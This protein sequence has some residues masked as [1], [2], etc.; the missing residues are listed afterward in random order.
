M[1]RSSS[2]SAV[3]ALALGLSLASAACTRSDGWTEP[4]A[5]PQIVSVT[6]PSLEGGT[7]RNTVECSAKNSGGACPLA[8]TVSFRLP[9]DQFVSKAY[10]RFQNDGSEDGVDREYLLEPRYGEGDAPV[11][12]LVNAQVP[13]ELI[14]VGALNRYSVRLLTGAGETSEPSTLPLSIQAP[15]PPER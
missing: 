3:G 9:E 6:G 2:S 14:R 12:V 5:R 11:T 1:R 10:V 7:V 4:G 13:P 15:R 8:V